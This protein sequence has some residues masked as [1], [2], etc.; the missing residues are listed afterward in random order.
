MVLRKSLQVYLE[1]WKLYVGIVL[2]TGFFLGILNV[3]VG[4]LNINYDSSG[5]IP[6][7]I[8]NLLT[9]V[10]HLLWIAPLIY[11][12]DKIHN[13]EKI[14]ITQAFKTAYNNLFRIIILA[15]IF[16]CL[17]LIYYL[18]VNYFS[19]PDYI[20][21]VIMLFIFIIAVWHVLF[22]PVWLLD[23]KPL[24]ESLAFSRKLLKDQKAAIFL[25]FIAIYISITV[26][27]FLAALI[28]F[29]PINQLMNINEM[30]VYYAIVFINGGFIRPLLYSLFVVW[31]YCHYKNL[32]DNEIHSRSK[33]DG[34]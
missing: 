29:W 19:A 34:E 23:N 1:N 16:T 32:I 27:F 20:V 5:K 2:V 26:V 15:I 30:A 25:E 14:S 8:F 7:V 22:I 6:L 24:N 10:G 12:L 33:V 9:Y 13:N 17:F 31:L 11:A 18:S 3:V 28:I 4:Y 21:F